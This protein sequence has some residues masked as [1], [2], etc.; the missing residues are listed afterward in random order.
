M[1]VEIARWFAE[2]LD[3]FAACGRGERPAEEA[4]RYYAVPLLLTTDAVVV[5]LSSAAEVGAWVRSQVDG[6]REAAYDH[7]EVLTSE[8][9]VVNASTALHRGEFSRRRADGT[10]ISRL[11]VT[12]VITEGAE[13]RRIAA[14]LVHPS[15]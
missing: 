10:E 4:L 9:S 1:D 13:G 3:A 15:A 8:T 12:Y 14:M 5:T 6:M 2:Y 11:G 7:S